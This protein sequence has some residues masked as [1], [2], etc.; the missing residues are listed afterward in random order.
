M[1]CLCSSV[2]D[3]FDLHDPVNIGDAKVGDFLRSKEVATARWPFK[4]IVIEGGSSNGTV[5]LGAYKILA[6]TKIL[7]S[8]TGFAGSSS[9]SIFAAFAAVRA[10][11]NF[12]ESKFAELNMESFKDDSFGI[13]RDVA[14]LLDGY[15]F[16]KGDVMEEWVESVLYEVTD[17]KRI[18][19]EQVYNMY[20]S[21][22]R[23]TRVN[24]SKLRVEYMS[25]ITTPDKP[26]SQAVRESA[27]I[28]IVFKAV[29]EGKDIIVDGAFGDPYP[30]DVFDL[31]SKPGTY[32]KE[33]F[34]IKIMSKK[35]EDRDDEIRDELG[36]E[37]TSLGGFVEAVLTFA[38]MSIERAKVR[39]GYWERTIS[40]DSPG[41]SIDN[42][43]V[44]NKEK[45]KE[46]RTGMTNT[47]MA[48]AKFLDVGHF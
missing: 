22:L 19:F 43:D 11:P 20:G 38:T 30:I 23:I 3:K 39:R 37:I 28:P 44:S 2:R 14:R 18:T 4:N 26:V 45:I 16:Y 21:D 33:T 12:I 15:G 25:R 9:G 10:P 29:R 7:D 47:V 31:K 5:T 40:L 42:F 35:L 8:L 6:E 48:L 46:I 24:L 41:R 27:S 13:F 17:L 1:G 36:Y 34:G 32:N